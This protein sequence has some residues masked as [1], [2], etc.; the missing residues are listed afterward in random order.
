MTGADIYGSLE[1]A[2]G[3]AS[4]AADATDADVM[5]SLLGDFIALLFMPF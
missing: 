2:D 4:V 1:I 5:A 3:V